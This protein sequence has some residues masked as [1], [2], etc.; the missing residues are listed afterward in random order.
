MMK[1][2]ILTTLSLALILVFTDKRDQ[3]FASQATGDGIQWLSYEE[4]RMQG[5][6]QHKKVFLV[7]LADWCQYCHKMNKETFQDPTVIAYVNQNFI[8]ISVDL[9]KEQDIGNKYQVRGLPTTFFLSEKGQRIANRPGF[10]SSDDM[11]NLLKYYDT[12]S[13]QSMSYTDFL[14]KKK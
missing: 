12:D 6:A 10:I 14:K 5:E 2:W 1:K 3:L 9:D 11:L 4:G 7:F 13:Y 8:P